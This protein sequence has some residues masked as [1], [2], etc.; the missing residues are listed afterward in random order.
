M[1]NE[2]WRD[3]LD[4]DIEALIEE[5]KQARRD[6]NFARADYIRNLLADTGIVLWDTKSGVRWERLR[7]L[8]EIHRQ[9]D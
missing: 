9:T 5:L 7:R 1:N 6:C 3:M 8:S 4:A 2:N